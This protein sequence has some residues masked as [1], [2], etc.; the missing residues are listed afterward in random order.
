MRT[1][2]EDGEAMS[3][4]KSTL[5]QTSTADSAAEAKWFAAYT[6]THHEKSVSQQLA[7][8]GVE[9]FYPTYKTRRQWKK[10]APE[11]AEL[12]LFPNYVFVRIARGERVAVLGTPGVFSLV[13]SGQKPW[14]LPEREIEVLRSGL[15]ERK[16]E[17][18]E[19]LVV[20]ERARVA[21]GVLQ[22]L[23]GVILRKKNSLQI[24]LSLDQIM[25]S[26][27]IEVDA[28]EL[29][30]VTREP[31]YGNTLSFLVTSFHVGKRQGHSWRQ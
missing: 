16:V 26:I 27:A 13:G 15:H 29:E 11:T 20:G 6:A 30:L 3:A 14:E 17:P 5:A 28:R 21:S 4:I 8:R 23:E 9:S 19:F 12:P 22:G 24:V 1:P 25:Q 18:H 2:S 31:N 7:E 10:R